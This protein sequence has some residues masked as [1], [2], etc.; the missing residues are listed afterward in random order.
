MVYQMIV[1]QVVTFLGIVFVL[2]KLLYTET[3]KEVGRLRELKNEVSLQQRELQKKIEDAENIYKEKMLEAKRDIQQMRLKAEEDVRLESQKIVNEAK[4]ES[5]EITRAVL[6]AK[7]KIKEEIAMNMR[8]SLPKMAS[9]I[10]KEVLSFQARGIVHKELMKEVVEKIEKMEKEKFK[11]NTGEI[12][13]T[14]PHAL[15]KK[16]KKQIETLISEKRGCRVNLKEKEDKKIVAGIIIDLGT[17]MID[18]SL[19]DRLNQIEERLA[20]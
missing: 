20:G 9:R 17:F 12:T 7:E 16:D 18:G 10:F 1:I 14:V 19:A 5:E 8:K 4:K 3:A 13:I 11:N 2:R 6:N 15:D